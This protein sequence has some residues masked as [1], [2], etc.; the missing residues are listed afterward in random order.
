[1]AQIGMVKCY[2]ATPKMHYP[3]DKVVLLFTDVFGLALSNMVRVH[4]Y[5]YRAL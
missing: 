2:I 5:C 3:D 4:A 1:M